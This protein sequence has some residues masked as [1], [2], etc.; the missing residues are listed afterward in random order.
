[1]TLMD[2]DTLLT[3]DEPAFS[4]H[5]VKYPDDR[6]TWHAVHSRYRRSLYH[7][8]RKYCS[9]EES[10][11]VVQDALLRVYRHRTTF[12]GGIFAAWLQRTAHNVLLNLHR[13]KKIRKEVY[14]SN[15]DGRDEC[16][17]FDIC[18]LNSWSPHINHGR[19]YTPEHLV[20]LKELKHALGA[21][22]REYCNE[23]QQAILGLR[24]EGLTYEEIAL[25]LGLK[26]PITV[27]TNFHRAK[28][29]I[30]EHLPIDIKSDIFRGYS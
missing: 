4:T 14:F 29:R 20:Y 21:V 8:A 2:L 26:T 9:D 15:T 3:M 23:Q 1:M 10:S 27:G 30:A 6:M 28:K 7:H 22:T 5:F 12:H 24:S 17:F 19:V 25:E 11:D 16:T 18:A 13:Y